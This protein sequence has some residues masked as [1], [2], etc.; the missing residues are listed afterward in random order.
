MF[1]GLISFAFSLHCFIVFGG[2]AV[3]RC[4]HSP[5]LQGLLQLCKPL[6]KS[7]RTR[8]PRGWKGLRSDGRA[9][10]LPG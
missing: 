8:T 6:L 4:F 10:G 5:V 2:Q 3:V 7:G 1:L 9:H